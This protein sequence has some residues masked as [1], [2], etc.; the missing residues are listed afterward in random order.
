[1]RFLPVTASGCQLVATLGPASFDSIAALAAAGATAFRLNASHM[2]PAELR[3]R[4]HQLRAVL[5]EA[6][7]VVDLQGAKMRLGRFAERDVH[8]GE[9]VVFV[10]AWDEAHAVPLPHGEL[11]AQTRAGETLSVDDDRLHFRVVSGGPDCIETEALAA[12]RLR[13]RKGVNLIEHPVVLDDLTC[14][15]A[16][17]VDAL[18]G[19]SGIAW[20]FSF[21]VDG[22]EA[23]WVRRRRPGAEVVAKIERR[24]AV[25][26]IDAIAS[27]CDA[28]WLCRGDLGA[29]LGMADLARCVAVIDPRRLSRPILMAG[30]VLEH[31]THHA[32]PTRSEVCHVFDLISRG[33]AGIVLSDETAIGTDPIQAVR[34]AA[35]LIAA[36]PLS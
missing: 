13:P 25:A 28:L 27:R 3:A 23:E 31:L 14:G 2:D 26:Q 17:A 32:E 10:R 11:F 22:H 5:P 29:Q 7:I 21:M 1:M 33:Y 19:R 12:G 34:V 6:P 36:T 9:R 30:Q 24:E 20:A 4:V 35:S 16:D 15:D 8:A 18:A